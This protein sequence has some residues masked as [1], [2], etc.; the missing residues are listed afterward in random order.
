MFSHVEN[1]PKIAIT[2]LDITVDGNT[3]F[4][5]SFQHLTAIDKQERPVDRWVRVTN[6]YRKI[7]GKWL[8]ALEHISV[9]VDFLTG[10]L[11]PL[12][13]P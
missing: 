1:T 9:P 5:H 4:G 7:G 11:V 2:D 12:S 13:K 3:G 10:K 6:G 8:I